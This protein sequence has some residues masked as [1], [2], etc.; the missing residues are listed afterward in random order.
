[1]TA[2]PEASLPADTD[3]FVPDG[4]DGPGALTRVTDLGVVAHPDDL[5]FCAVPAIAA[6]RDDPHRWFGGLTCTDGAGSARTGPFA[7]FGA[8]ELVEARRSEQRDAATIGGYGFVAQLGWP[9]SMVKSAEGHARL[10]ELVAGLLATCRPVNVLTHNLADKHDT[11]IAVAT[12][13][14][15]AV[16]SLPLEQRPGR[17]VGVEAWRDLD[18][19]PDAEKVRLDV[20][21][22]AA[23]ADELAAVFVSQIE[24]GKRYDAAAAGRRRAN[25]TY[26][27]SH[28]VDDAEQVV[29]AMD[30]TPLTRNDDL[31]PV[32]FVTAAIDR[33]RDEVEGALR[34][35]W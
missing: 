20:T 15:D 34:R 8:D 27:A 9:S 33:F 6:C 18:W 10:T 4:L 21:A 2:T 25:A 16:R 30:L 5:E 22:H 14:I 31:D 28:R 1:M 12:A 32:R 24:G 19:L 23:L 3:L 17:V 29:V 35:W 7:T 13:L 26:F 11:H